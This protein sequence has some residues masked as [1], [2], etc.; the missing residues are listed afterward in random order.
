MTTDAIEW[1]VKTRD[2]NDAYFDSAR[3]NDFPFRDGDVVVPTLA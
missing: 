1:P 3:W 2:L